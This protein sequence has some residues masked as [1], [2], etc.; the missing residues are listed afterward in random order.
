MK[1]SEPLLLYSF[2]ATVGAAVAGAFLPALKMTLSK[3]VDD[4]KG[5]ESSS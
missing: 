2:A 5:A 4:L 1:A 3:P